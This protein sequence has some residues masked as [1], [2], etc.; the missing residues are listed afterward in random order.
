MDW[1]KRIPFIGSRFERKPRVAV[2]TL[3]GVIGQTGVM[4]R[5]GLT[6]ANLRENIEEAFDLPRVKAVALQVNS[7]GGSPVQSALIAGFIR[8]LADEKEVPV[9]AFCEDVAASG[10]YWLACSADEIYAN[11]ASIVGSIGVV[12][13]GFGFPELIEKLGIERR[14]YTAGE[15][16]RR[17]DPFLPEAQKDVTYLKSLQKELHEQFKDYVKERRGERLTGAARTLFSGDFW[18]GFRAKDMGLIDG[19][20]DMRSVMREKFGEKVRFY[21]IK[22]QKGFLA[23]KLGLAARPEHWAEDLIAALEA[24]ALWNRYGL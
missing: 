13:A 20:G 23:R 22:E 12:T 5:G 7:P 2:L 21:P 4:R 24:R 18:T 3:A 9:Y 17:L 16:K 15:N 1:I 11:G 8:A 6:L 10:G 14:V 19:L